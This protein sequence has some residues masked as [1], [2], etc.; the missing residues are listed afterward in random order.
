MTPSGI[1]PAT[2]RHEPTAPPR[3]PPRVSTLRKITGSKI[4]VTGALLPHY[5]VTSP[6]ECPRLSLLP[7][8]MF[9]STQLTPVFSPEDEGLGAY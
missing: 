3:A 8:N 4:G 5:R 6:S 7:Y 9:L 1:E 2:L